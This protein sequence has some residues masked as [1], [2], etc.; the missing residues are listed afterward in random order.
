MSAEPILKWAG[1]KRQLL[2]RLLPLVPEYTGKYIEPFVGGGAMFFALVPE[3]AVIS[4]CNEE[5]INLYKTVKKSPED[6]ISRLQKY[7]NTERDF[8]KIRAKDWH[9]LEKE[10]AAAE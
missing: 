2:S 10:D 4:D 8:Y 7:K 3:N 6:V 9:E 5:L 1:G